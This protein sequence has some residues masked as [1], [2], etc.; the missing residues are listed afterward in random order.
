MVAPTLLTFQAYPSFWPENTRSKKYGQVF[1]VEHVSHSHSPNIR[2]WIFRINKKVT[3][4]G[5]RSL[6]CKKWNRRRPFF[7]S[8]PW[9]SW[10]L[11][12]K[13]LPRR[14]NSSSWCAGLRVTKCLAQP[15]LWSSSWTWWSGGGRR[16]TTGPLSS[17]HSESISSLVLD[18]PLLL[19]PTWPDKFN[20]FRKQ[21]L[22]LRVCT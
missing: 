19:V 16:Q 2:S 3:T 13:L 7:R 22:G 17:S 5:Q 21:T 1:T 8:S 15:T 9:L 6:G 20:I 18:L 4:D 10:W 14:A 11:A 12:W